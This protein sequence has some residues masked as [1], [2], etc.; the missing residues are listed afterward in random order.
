MKDEL[1][2]LIHLADSMHQL[3]EGLET[4]AIYLTGHEEKKEE[5]PEPAAPQQVSL[6]DVRTVLA[7]KS[8]A[9][10]T[11]EVRALIQ[12][13]GVEK[14]SAVKP[15]DYAALKVKAEVL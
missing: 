15:E 7:A 13:F 10:H 1:A 4:M 9:G 3:A 11:D 5:K 6:E 2:A 14:L 8:A 12:E